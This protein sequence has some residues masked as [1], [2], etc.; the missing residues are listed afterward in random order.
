VKQPSPVKLKIVVADDEPLVGSTLAEIL[1]SEGYD[2]VSVSDGLAA[3]ETVRA[4]QPD[5]LLTDV[6]MPGMNGIEVAKSIRASL[7]QCRIVLLSGQAATGELLE[8][9]RSEGH[10]FEIL[11]KPIHPGMLLSILRQSAPT[12]ES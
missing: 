4:L 6:M 5:I 7:P 9:A 8:R 12:S 11:T 1:E 3:L 2:V 10:E